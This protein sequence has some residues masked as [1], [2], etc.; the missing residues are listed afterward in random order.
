MCHHHDCMRSK[1]IIAMQFALLC[2]VRYNKG[3]GRI[4]FTDR[5][6]VSHLQTDLILY[7]THT[8]TC[9]HIIITFQINI[10]EYNTHSTKQNKH[11]TTSPFEVGYVQLGSYRTGGREALVLLCDEVS[12][13]SIAVSVGVLNSMS[14]LIWQQNN[15]SVVSMVCSFSISL[16]NVT[17]HLST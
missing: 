9:M 5:E 3:S 2:L 4:A 6:V 13:C 8:V 14:W 16:G 15:V 17:P 12:V 7:K 11:N 1:S 10:T